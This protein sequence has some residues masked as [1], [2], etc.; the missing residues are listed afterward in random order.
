MFYD[1]NHMQNS[2]SKMYNILDKVYTNN[3]KEKQC[4]NKY[5]N[6]RTIRCTH[7]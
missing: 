2:L 7:S 4:K 1:K 6:S 3:F 5:N